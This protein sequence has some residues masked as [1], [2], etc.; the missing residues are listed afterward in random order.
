M[1]G[2]RPLGPEGFFYLLR[3]SALIC[4]SLGSWG[5]DQK[6][7][8]PQRIT[9]ES[10]SLKR[11]KKGFWSMWSKNPPKLDQKTT[12]VPPKNNNGGS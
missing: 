11:V 9:N 6:C 5:S 2:S 7:Q 8:N 12:S 3:D 1:G 10:E 4:Y